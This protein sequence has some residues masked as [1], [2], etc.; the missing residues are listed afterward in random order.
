MNKIKLKYLRWKN[1]SKWIFKKKHKDTTLEDIFFS[2]KPT[3]TYPGWRHNFFVLYKAMKMNPKSRF[4]VIM[5]NECFLSL[6]E[7]KKNWKFAKHI[8]KDI[9]KKKLEE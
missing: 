1:T 7:S 8:F 4:M 6:R 3:N 5:V 9:I 2:I